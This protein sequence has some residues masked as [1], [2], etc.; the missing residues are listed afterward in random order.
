MQFL[1]SGAPRI[2]IGKE[3][4]QRLILS[5]YPISFRAEHSIDETKLELDAFDEDLIELE[6]EEDEESEL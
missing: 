6:S 4:G 1:G 5:K 2:E 3:P